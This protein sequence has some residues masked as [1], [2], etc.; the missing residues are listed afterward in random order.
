M[1]RSVEKVSRGQVPSLLRRA[2]PAPLRR[3][4]KI[5]LELFAGPGDRFPVL[6]AMTANTESNQ[7]IEAV[8]TEFAPMLQMMNL[9]FNIGATHLASPTVAL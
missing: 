5:L 9:Q 7:I 1:V 2:S 4:R 3:G 6:L 8:V